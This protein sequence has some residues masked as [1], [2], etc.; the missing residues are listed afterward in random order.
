MPLENETAQRVWHVYF[1]ELLRI[2]SCLVVMGMAVSTDSKFALTVSADPLIVR[3]DLD[4]GLLPIVPKSVPKK[5]S[6]GLDENRFT[7]QRIKQAGNGSVTL[8][9]DGR[10]CAVG[11]WDGK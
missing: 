8:R 1:F 7:K 11:G 3:Y 9:S 2:Y 5:P 6:K 10:I 4:V